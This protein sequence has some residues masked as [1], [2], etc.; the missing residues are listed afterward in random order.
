MRYV[1]MIIFESM[2]LRQEHCNT[3]QQINSSEKLRLLNWLIASKCKN[4]IFSVFSSHI[5]KERCFDG[6]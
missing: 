5:S 2:I 4:L 1:N 3:A 6:A